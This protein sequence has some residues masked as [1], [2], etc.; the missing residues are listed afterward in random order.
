MTIV[1]QTFKKSPRKYI[2]EDFSPDSM[3]IVSQEYKKLLE[4][5]IQSVKNLESLIYAHSELNTILWTAFIRK[6]VQRN[7]H[8]ND[9][10]INQ[11][12][13]QFYIN[14]YLPAL[15][16]D[17][18]IKQ[19]ILESQY[20]S[21]LSPEFHHMLSIFRNE[22]K[23]FSPLNRDLL[24]QEQK[25][26]RQ[27][28]AIVST[29]RVHF[30]GN[31]YRFTEMKPFLGDEDPQVRKSAYLAN[32]EGWW[33]IHDLLD[34]LYTRLIRVRVQIAQNAGFE[35]FRDYA[36]LS[37]GRIS[38]GPDDVLQYHTVLEHTI[39]PFCKQL[40]E[41]SKKRN[42]L[43]QLG[44]WD[45]RYSGMDYSIFSC[46]T[47]EQLVE[48]AVKVYN[49]VDPE[50]GQLLHKM[51]TTG[52]MNLEPREGK[53]NELGFCVMLPEEHAAFMFMNMGGDFNDFTILCHEGGHGMNH[54][55]ASFLQL[56]SYRIPRSEIGELCAMGIEKLVYANLDA[57]FSDS[58][59]KTQAELY[60]LTTQ[61]VKLPWFTIM[62]M[63]QHWVYLHPNHTVEERHAYYA[64][65]VDRFQQ[66]V[67]W[68]DCN[69]TKGIGW[70]QDSLPFWMPFY[71]IE[72]V[73]AE[74]GSMALLRNYRTNPQQTVQQ[75]KKLLGT[76]F[77]KPLPEVYST[78][79]IE[80]NLTE[81]Y[82]KKVLNFLQTEID[83]LI[84]RLK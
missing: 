62:D 84:P 6:H 5:K 18:Q 10:A 60:G 79:G 22:K 78:A 28:E 29:V 56:A 37:R 2:S 7:L 58:K 43:S 20:A 45:I 17:F 3:D 69:K 42:K 35:N 83:A 11:E 49:R 52:N 55:Y 34:D 32:Q 51:L 82:V 38:Y 39:V 76:H 9:D 74:I 75:F 30:N 47:S 54:I 19:A 66:G 4:K 26:I 12:M 1:E 72:Y 61:I 14:I 53:A 57:I 70:M 36:H 46:K 21:D 25:L 41:N 67:D 8:I 64:G 13:S 33:S 65:L 23:V 59:V 71:F 40:L 73:M 16:L 44:P 15:D 24:K 77:S 31:E 50:L 48:K 81:D 80:F 63:F 27:Y 68:S